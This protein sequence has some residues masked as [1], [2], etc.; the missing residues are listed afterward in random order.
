MDDVLPS[1]LIEFYSDQLGM[2]DEWTTV[3]KK[4][5]GKKGPVE[6]TEKEIKA[7]PSPPVFRP[8]AHLINRQ[9]PTAPL[10]ALPSRQMSSSSSAHLQPAVLQR[11]APPEGVEVESP[12]S[13]LQGDTYY[14]VRGH[15]Q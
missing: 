5:A 3:V 8:P 6:A 15:V 12:G 1:H 14:R 2:D 11:L 9:R 4:K 13:R 7:A 10:V